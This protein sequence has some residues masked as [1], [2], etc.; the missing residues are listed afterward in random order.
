MNKKGERFIS[1]RRISFARWMAV[2]DRVIFHM[3]GC[4][5]EGLPDFEYWL[6][7]NAGESSYSTARQAV[8]AANHF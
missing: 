1:Y 4:T 7:W 2:V 8:Q 3:T 6:A 5:S